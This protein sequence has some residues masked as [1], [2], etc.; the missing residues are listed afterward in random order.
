MSK[1]P[2]LII[3]GGIGGLTTSL[4]LAK[5]GIHSIVLEQGKHFRTYGSG[6]QF[7]PN[8]FKVIDYLG[9]MPDFVKIA[10]FPEYLCYV[11]GLTG[12]EYV[13]LPLGKRIEERF[14]YPFGSFHREHVMKAFYEACEKSPFIKLIPSANVVKVWEEADKACA[15]TDNGE[16]YEGELMI[17]C[18][19]VWSV[20]RAYIKEGQSDPLRVSSQLI[21]R[22]VVHKDKMPKGLEYES[23][24]HY[25][26]PNAH[27]VFYP[28]GNDGYFN[29][30]A[31]F[32]SD[33]VPDAH[34]HDGNKKEL[35]SWYEGSIPKVMEL[36]NSVNCERVWSLN[37]RDPVRNWSRGR[38]TMLG[39]AAHPTLP[40]LTS[41]AGMAIEDAV[42]LAEKIHDLSNNFE[43]AFKEYEEER[44]LRTAYVQLFSRAYGDVHHSS[45]VARELR[46]ELLSKRTV[47]QNYNWVSFLYSGIDL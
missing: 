30:S 31:I 47:D 46:N 5:K 40:Y 26:R 12:Q 2:I 10:I 16:K 32:Q 15:M 21:Y 18:D 28:I 13:R 6:I 44:H 9:I 23:I 24:V 3:G 20:V 41:G 14:D 39:D 35:L 4:A 17:G 33:R 25:A 7:C 43:Q 34:E 29:I 45:G 19:G 8:T 37:D 1:L 42:V 11:D 22:G 27:C 38:V 36:I